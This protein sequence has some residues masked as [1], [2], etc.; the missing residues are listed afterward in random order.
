[1]VRPLGHRPKRVDVLLHKATNEERQRIEGDRHS[2]KFY[3]HS[4]LLHTD[5]WKEGRKDY[6]DGNNLPNNPRPNTFF[7]QSITVGL[8]TT[9]PWAV[10]TIVVASSSSHCIS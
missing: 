1:M 2:K 6:Y 7:M 4:Y 8:V 5:G 9:F 10:G 3:L